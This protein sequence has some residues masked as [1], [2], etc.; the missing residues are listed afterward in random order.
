MF[1]FIYVML[2]A[3]PISIRRL[4][5]LY[6]VA[7]AS[8]RF[9]LSILRIEH[10]ASLAV[11]LATTIALLVWVCPLVRVLYD[12]IFCKRIALEAFESVSACVRFTYGFVLVV[13]PLAT[14]V[15]CF[16]PHALI[17]AT[18]IRVVAVACVGGVSLVI[19]VKTLLPRLSAVSTRAS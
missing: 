8:A 19:A 5:V 15:I 12:A 18:L 14:V 11:E 16:A 6:I 4:C 10:A 2:T 3:K 9:L 7:W 1:G 13:L 17:Q